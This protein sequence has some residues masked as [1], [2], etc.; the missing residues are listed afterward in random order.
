MIPLPSNILLL[1]ERI[2]LGL[3]VMSKVPHS[4]DLKKSEFSHHLFFDFLMALLNL[5]CII[6]VIM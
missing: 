5:L 1:L 2:V 4:T 3:L 6:L